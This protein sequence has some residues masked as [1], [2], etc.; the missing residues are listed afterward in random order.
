MFCSLDC[1]SVDECLYEELGEFAE[2]TLP[3]SPRSAAGQLRDHVK[4]LRGMSSLNDH[5]VEAIT[6]NLIL[7]E[8]FT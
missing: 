1:S 8:K 3:G 5:S 6:G 7:E 2:P 4:P